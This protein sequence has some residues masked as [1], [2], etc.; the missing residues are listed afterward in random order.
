MTVWTMPEFDREGWAVCL[1]WL[2]GGKYNETPTNKKKT[3]PYESPLGTFGPPSP[4]KRKEGRAAGSPD[5]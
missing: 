5:D 4:F 2:Q 3:N 1:F